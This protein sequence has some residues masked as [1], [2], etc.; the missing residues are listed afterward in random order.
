VRDVLIAAARQLAD[1]W[2]AEAAG[3]FTPHDVAN[4]LTT[5]ASELVAEIDR[6]DRETRLLTVE[7]YAA[8]HG[9]HPS[10]VR[11]WC[12]RGELDATRNDAGDWMI[13]RGARRRRKAG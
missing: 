8:A 9:D 3:R 5:C 12:L 7:Q 10:S 2:K 1:Q 4:A 6:V 13:V 11:R